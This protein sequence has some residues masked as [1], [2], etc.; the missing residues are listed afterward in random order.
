MADLRS[1]FHIYIR[2]MALNNYAAAARLSLN[3]TLYYDDTVFIYAAQY[4]M[5]HIIIQK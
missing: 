1:H 4:T 5:R 3:S 2:I